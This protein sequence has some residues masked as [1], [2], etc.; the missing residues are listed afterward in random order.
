MAYGDQTG[1][2]EFYVN[3]YKKSVSVLLSLSSA[4]ND[5]L[6]P[7]FDHII[8]APQKLFNSFIC[9]SLNYLLAQKMFVFF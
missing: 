3:L 7:I 4:P 8:F 1:F 9:S 2:P 5:R 6:F